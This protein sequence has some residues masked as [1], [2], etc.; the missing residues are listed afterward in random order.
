MTAL[1]PPFSGFPNSGIEFLEEMP[2]RDKEWFADWRDLYDESL[3]T[4]AKSL[5]VS[6]GQ[7]LQKSISPN[8]IAKPQINGSLSPIFRDLR[9]STDKTTFKDHILLNFWEGKNKKTAPTLRIR[10]TPQSIGFATGALFHLKPELDKWRS[11]ISTPDLAS[12]LQFYIDEL[13]S[14][15]D[16]DIPHPELTNP[17]P[18]FTH[19]HTH[20]DLLRR[21][22]LQI[23]WQE[24]TPIH[25]SQTDFSDWC[26]ERLE[27]TKKIHLWLSTNL[28]P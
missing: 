6:V 25:I 19:E 3:L 24:P 26:C 4:P 23:R 8:L 1:P 17:P 27:K 28:I 7:R 13:R 2:K 18:P 21:K 12:E 5:I 15:H 10:I 14:L 20:A 22:S 16:I 11:A 9:F